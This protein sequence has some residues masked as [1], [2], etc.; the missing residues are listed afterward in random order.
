MERINNKDEA[1]A[2][3]RLIDSGEL[4]GEAKSKALTEIGRAH[5]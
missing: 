2:V 1:N 3:V 4:T 5:V